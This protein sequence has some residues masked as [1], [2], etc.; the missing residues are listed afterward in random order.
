MSDKN[1]SKQD[2][3][4][5]YGDIEVTFSSYYKYSFTFK[6]TTDAGE[7]LYVSIGGDSDEIYRM[8][9]MADDP[10]SVRSLDPYQGSVRIGGELIERFYDF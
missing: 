1:I 2:F 4:D 6:G 10:E 9:I 7:E 8:E 5:K 3:L